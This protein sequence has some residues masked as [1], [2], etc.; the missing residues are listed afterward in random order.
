M[1]NSILEY[2]TSFNDAVIETIVAFANTQGG[3]VLIGVNNYGNPIKNIDYGVETFQK[4]I[5]EIKNKTQPPIILDIKIIDYYNSKIAELTI[6]ESPIKP[7][8]FK[9]RYYKE[10]VIL[11]IYCH[12]LE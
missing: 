3:T 12:L 4:W 10:L 8:S 6:P 7:V 9:G 5:N 1:E 2:K 11:I